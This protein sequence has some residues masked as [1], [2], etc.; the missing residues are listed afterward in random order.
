[1]NAAQLSHIKKSV[2]GPEAFDRLI[3]AR[4]PEGPGCCSCSRSAAGFLET[5]GGK[6]RP[7]NN[8]WVSA[9]ITCLYFCL[10][11]LVKKMNTNFNSVFGLVTI[12]LQCYITMFYFFYVA[13]RQ[14]PTFKSSISSNIRCSSRK[15]P[16]VTSQWP[17]IPLPGQ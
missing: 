17:S 8:S 3:S 7:E 4:I 12:P 15:R 1:M 13:E 16:S 11:V 10:F 5:E 6:L 9:T 2:L 14:S